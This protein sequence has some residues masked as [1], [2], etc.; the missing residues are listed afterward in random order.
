MSRIHA[1]R[2]V[3]EG[4]GMCEAQADDYFEI[5]EDGLVH[6]RADEV[7]EADS[8]HVRAAVDSCPVSALRLATS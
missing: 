1:D 2:T 6:V 5:G 7:A 3:C 4:I 8:A